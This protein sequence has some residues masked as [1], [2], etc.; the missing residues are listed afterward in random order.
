MTMETSIC[1]AHV[2]LEKKHD[3]QPWFV[4]LTCLNPCLMGWSGDREKEEL[5]HLISESHRGSAKKTNV[6][7]AK[8]CFLAVLGLTLAIPTR[9]VHSI[10]FHRGNAKKQSFRAWKFVVLQSLISSIRGHSTKREPQR[11]I[12]TFQ[13]PFCKTHKSSRINSTLR[14]WQSYPRVPQILKVLCAWYSWKYAT[15]IGSEPLLYNAFLCNTQAVS[16]PWGWHDGL[17][18]SVVSVIS[19]WMRINYLRIRIMIRIL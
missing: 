16:P 3:D 13:V 19:R 17:N 9:R 1:H 5:Q 10:S 12:A 18:W 11:G 6:R 2:P 8:K 14:I 15:H 7:V 4:M